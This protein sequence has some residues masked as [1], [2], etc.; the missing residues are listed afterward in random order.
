MHS[1]LPAQEIHS[2]SSV[3][4]HMNN[5]G[6]K[7]FKKDHLYKH[8]KLWQQ[9]KNFCRSSQVN[10]KQPHTRQES[11]RYSPHTSFQW[12]IQKSK[13][14][15]TRRTLQKVQ[16]WKIDSKKRYISLT[17]VSEI[18]LDKLQ[19]CDSWW[20]AK[21]KLIKILKLMCN[22]TFIQLVKIGSVIHYFTFNK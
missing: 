12:S 11:Y 5:P 20:L 21:L 2:L 9:P 17:G 4:M 1:Y 18:L 7:P 3:V 14:Y 10:T 19:T 8:P 22:H 15:C 6:L 13:Q 16:H